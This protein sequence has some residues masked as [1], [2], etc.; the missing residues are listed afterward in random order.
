L[1]IYDQKPFKQ[2][3]LL[4]LTRAFPFLQR[5]SIYDRNV[6]Y[7][8]YEEYQLYHPDW[9]S[10]VHFPHLTSLDFIDTTSYCI[11]HFLNEKKTYLPCLTELKTTYERLQ[12]VT[13]YFTNDKTRH[14]CAHVKRLILEHDFVF[15]KEVY[16]YFPLL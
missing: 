1:K 16:Q 12:R 8:T 14:N 11:E 13:K 6:S 3:Y 9:C 10:L 15:L 4:R 7:H 5:L 2:E